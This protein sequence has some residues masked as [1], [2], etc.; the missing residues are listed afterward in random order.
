MS[1]L[2]D[3]TMTRAVAASVGEKAA[4]DATRAVLSCPK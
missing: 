1:A 2:A 4:V 3:H